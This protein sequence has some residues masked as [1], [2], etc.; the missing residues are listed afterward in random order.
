MKRFIS[1]FTLLLLTL[2]ACD[3]PVSQLGSDNKTSIDN[4]ESRHSYHSSSAP[5]DSMRQAL[6][7]QFK[8]RYGPEWRITWGDKT[9][10]P[11]TVF[12]G[13]TQPV[14]G[15]PEQAAREFLAQNQSL[16]G[17][18]KDLADLNLIEVDLSPRG[19]RHVR[20]QQT[21][22]GTPIYDATYQVH[23]RP[24]GRIDMANG[25]YYPNIEVSTDPSV[26]AASAI[27]TVE[28]DLGA[29]TILKEIPVT[30]LMIFRNPKTDAFALTWR[31][32][33]A[34]KGLHWQYFIDA[35][36]GQVLEKL[37]MSTS[38]TGDGDII[39]ETSCTT[40]NPVNRDL[41]RLFGNG[42]LEGTYANV[43]NEETSRAFSQ[44]N[45][46][47]YAVDNTHFEEVNVYYHIDTYR[48]N[49]LDNI[50]L[51]GEK[52]GSDLD[53]E[54]FVHDPIYDASYIFS[55]EAVRFGDPPDFALQDE[56]IYHEFVHAAADA[57]NGNHRID[58]WDDEEG[59]IGEGTADYFP[60][61]FTGDAQ[62]GICV[63]FNPRDM[64]NPDI[65][66]YEDYLNNLPVGEHEGGEFFSAILWDLRNSGEI[67]SHDADVIIFEAIPRLSGAPDFIEYR[68]AMMA[69]DSDINSGIFNDL[70]QNT[71]ADWGVG[72]HVVYEV[73]I[74]G[75]GSVN[76]GE[77]GTWYANSDNGVSPYSYVWYTRSSSMDPW[78]QVGTG[79]SYSQAVLSDFELKL[80]GTDGNSDT[81]T[82]LHYVTK[83]CDPC[84]WTCPCSN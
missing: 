12:S 3:S 52:I 17:M 60:G 39:Q 42:Y 9:G 54:A 67:S 56:V 36:N 51:A 59:A 25:H 53:L 2:A 78:T 22:K 48:H 83:L 11:R 62:I 70:I 5:D 30:E 24:D 47:Q 8:I 4:P 82:D 44:N 41:F 7:Q 20:F 76:N 18:R 72:E 65:A 46:F 29:Q 66:T 34:E 45:S 38:I 1:L 35:A 49:Y 80:E 84:D 23:I 14:K 40:P 50:G 16:F 43:H 58:P 69:V 21:Y 37:E 74:T 55:Q 26:S 28:A 15:D 19:N 10:T 61:S 73:T 31:V 77:S 27:R 33:I 6:W 57:V 68:D 81:A 13:T 63:L 71:F 75:P 64:E 79:S 32:V